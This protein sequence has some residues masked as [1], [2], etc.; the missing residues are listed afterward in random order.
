MHAA[1]KEKER[2]QQAE[3]EAAAAAITAQESDLTKDSGKEG[4][5]RR[6][7]SEPAPPEVLTERDL[8]KMVYVTLMETDTDFLLNM[9]CEFLS[10]YLGYLLYQPTCK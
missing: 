8:E 1:Q 7:T 6:T 3:L 9:P 10:D 2:A 5:K 4:R